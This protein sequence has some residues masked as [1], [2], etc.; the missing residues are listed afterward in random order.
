MIPLCSLDKVTFTDEDGTEWTFLPF[1]G[2]LEREFIAVCE[3]ANKEDDSAV[4]M[5]DELAKKV[6]ISCRPKANP[7]Y[8]NGK[9]IVEELV[10]S[11]KVK[12]IVNIWQ[13]ANL[14]T[15]EQKKN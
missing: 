14:L 6:I 10:I 5:I 7:D 12:A 3:A 15:N 9:N 4:K 8:F 1:T 2:H 13:R 11:E